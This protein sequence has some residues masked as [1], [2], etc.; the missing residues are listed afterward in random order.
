[1]TSTRRSNPQV[2]DVSMQQAMN[3]QQSA[4]VHLIGK[5]LSIPESNNFV[6]GIVVAEALSRAAALSRMHRPQSF[7]FAVLREIVTVLE[8]ARRELSNGTLGSYQLSRDE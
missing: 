1:M 7:S 4:R 8:R 3:A 5:Y 2:F 6:H